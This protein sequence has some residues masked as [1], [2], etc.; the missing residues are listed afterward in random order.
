MNILKKLEVYGDTH[1]PKWLDL[2]RIVLGIILFVKGINFI[3][4]TEALMVLLEESRFWLT[5]YYLVHYIVIAHL[6]GGLLITV[7]LLT[8]VAI[9]FQIPI[10]LGA[11]IFINFP[12]GQV[13]TGAELEL[14][15]LVLVLLVFFLIFGSG[16]ISVDN[17]LSKRKKS[18]VEYE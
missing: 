7:G 9:I 4:D 15:I 16:P 14:S 5:G 6:A 13:T 11:V 10:L 2:V 17:M 3:S 12:H 1:H 8:R 18:S